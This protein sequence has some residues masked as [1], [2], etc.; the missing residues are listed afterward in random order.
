MIV[1]PRRLARGFRAVARRCVSGRPRGPAPPVALDVRAGVLTVCTT[2]GDTA[3]VYGTPAAGA[4]ETAVVPMAVLDAVAGVGDDAAELT[5][6]PDLRGVA[7]WA[8]R[9]GPRTHRFDAIRPGDRHRPPDP[10]AAWHP[11]PADFPAALHACGRAAAAD[12]ARFALHRVQVQGAA[13]RV[14]GTD[15]ATALLWGGFDLPF[16]ADLLV[17]AVPAFGTPELAGEPGVRVG[18]TATHLAVEA[19]PWRVFLPVDPAGK[20]PD[21]AGVVPKT[22][23]TAAGLD[24]RDA[25]DLLAALPGLPGADAA[26]RPVTLALDGRVVV[27]AR[28]GATGDVREVR[29]GRSPSSGP[30][31]AVAVD[32]R[33][34]ARALALGCVTLRLA[35]GRPVVFAGGDKTLVVA[36]LDPALV[37]RPAGP[38]PADLADAGDVVTTTTAHPEPEP[39][40]TPH[41]KTGYPPT[42]RP[43]PPDPPDPLAAAEELRAA[44]ADAAARAGR[45][46]AALKHRRRGERALTQAWTSLKALHLDPGG[47]P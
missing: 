41:P 26:C 5:V 44:L 46:V 33:V 34:L 39:D 10:P 15:G 20:Y 17:P 7:R 13:G 28:D 30:A 2:T 14:V 18:R 31:A 36:P 11:A 25:A 6:G 22:A 40:M 24:G 9:G 4:D 45:L 3:L 42:G 29:L 32:R 8:D 27:R 23:P 1:I 12:A 19:G 43:D 47:R 37:V 21:V 35:P 38:T 16:A